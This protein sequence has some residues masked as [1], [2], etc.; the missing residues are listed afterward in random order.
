MISIDLS[1]DLEPQELLD[2][3][4]E[5][6]IPEMQRISEKRGKSLYSP[7]NPRERQNLKDFIRFLGVLWGVADRTCRDELG[8]AS[9]ILRIEMQTFDDAFIRFRFVS[10]NESLEPLLS[11]LKNPLLLFLPREGDGERFRK[12]GYVYVAAM[13]YANP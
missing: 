13:V 3:L 11:E 7:Q 10:M 2:A 9:P 5:K 4:R 8:Y 1:A 12:E 6:F